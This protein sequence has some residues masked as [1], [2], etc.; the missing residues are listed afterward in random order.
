MM[1]RVRKSSSTGSGPRK[2]HRKSANIRVLEIE[3]AD[4]HDGYWGLGRRA[5]AALGPP[6][7]RMGGGREGED[8]RA[9]QALRMQVLDLIEKI[10][11]FPTEGPSTPRNGVLGGCTKALQMTISLLEDFCVD[12]NGEDKLVVEE[13]DDDDN[14]DNDE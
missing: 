13:E 7:A 9:Y 4:P 14:D 12:A 10:P 11:L 8:V 2:G 3:V 6:T 1:K 5:E